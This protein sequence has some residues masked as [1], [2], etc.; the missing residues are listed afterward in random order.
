MRQESPDGTHHVEPIRCCCDLNK[1]APRFSLFS[2]RTHFLRSTSSS[3]LAAWPDFVQHD[4]FGRVQ[5]VSTRFAALFRST[6]LPGEQLLPLSAFTS[7]CVHC[8]ILLRLAL[9][10]VALLRLAWPHLVVTAPCHLTSLC[11]RRFLA[12]RFSA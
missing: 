5:R 8:F 9:P 2:Y 3:R 1:H 12:L 11:L 4:E 10:L 6:N 7:L